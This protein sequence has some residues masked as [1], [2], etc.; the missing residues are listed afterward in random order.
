MSD[1]CSAARSGAPAAVTRT[2]GFWTPAATDDSGTASWVPAGTMVFVEDCSI[3]NTVIVAVAVTSPGLDRMTRSLVPVSTV[4]PMSHDSVLGSR[5]ALA[6]RPERSSAAR[7]IDSAAAMVAVD[8]RSAAPTSFSGPAAGPLKSAVK[9]SDA[10]SSVSSP[11]SPC[12]AVR[13][14]PPADDIWPA[15]CVF[16]P[17]ARNAPLHTSVV[18]PAVGVTD[19]CAGSLTIPGH[20]SATAA[21]TPSTQPAATMAPISRRAP[22]ATTRIARF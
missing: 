1:D 13:S 10:V 22:V 17:I 7:E 4:P 8:P 3:P 15:F 2:T 6:A 20:G 19:T 5:H 16:L 21:V 18:S 9:R 11:V 12:S 14:D